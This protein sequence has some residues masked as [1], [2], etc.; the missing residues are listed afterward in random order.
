VL[1]VRD[2]TGD[3]DDEEGLIY[4]NTVDKKVRCYADGDWRDLAT[5]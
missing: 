1:R 2:A 4:V 3:L 5:W